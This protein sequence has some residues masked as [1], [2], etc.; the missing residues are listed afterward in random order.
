MTVDSSHS[1]G[2]TPEHAYSLDYTETYAIGVALGSAKDA[3]ATA[4][5]LARRGAHNPR[6]PQTRAAVNQARKAV[7]NALRRLDEETRAILAEQHPG[8]R[9]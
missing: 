7:D 8:G 5:G 2:V 1:S 3:L 6:R 9:E 4:H